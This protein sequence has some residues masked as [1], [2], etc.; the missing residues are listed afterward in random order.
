MEE[1]KLTLSDFGNKDGFDLNGYL[2]Y[3]FYRCYENVGDQSEDKVV[4]QLINQ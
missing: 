4:K 1:K 3:L 2:T